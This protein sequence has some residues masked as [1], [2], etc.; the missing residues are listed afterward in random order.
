M[1]W[2]TSLGVNAV[3]KRRLAAERHSG[4]LAARD[5]QLLRRALER[6]LQVR[7]GLV[8]VRFQPDEAGLG[9]AR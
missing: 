6:L 3:V 7:D 8:S 2:L 4:L 9:R 1:P 5:A